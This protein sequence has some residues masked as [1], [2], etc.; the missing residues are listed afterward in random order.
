MHRGGHL[1]AEAIVE[2]HLWSPGVHSACVGGRWCRP[3]VH[4]DHRNIVPLESPCS[5]GDCS[6]VLH[7]SLGSSRPLRSVGSNL[8]TW[9]PQHQSSSSWLTPSL[10]W[11]HPI[12]NVFHTVTGSPTASATSLS[13]HIADSS[14]ASCTT[15]GTNLV[16]L[17]NP[18]HK[19]N[20]DQIQK[21][22]TY[23]HS[24]RIHCILGAI[25]IPLSTMYQQAEGCT[26][27]L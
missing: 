1:F 3:P 8:G 17:Y 14:S 19:P 24:V 16:A 22:I 25:P 7:W 10:N 21:Y 18:P 13:W 23:L 6:I 20:M 4:Y 9:L 26:T 27:N 12:A 2:G 11:A 5:D 15:V